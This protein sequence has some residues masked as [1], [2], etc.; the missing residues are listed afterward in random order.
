MVSAGRR[1]REAP[2]I[3]TAVFGVVEVVSILAALADSRS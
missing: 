3:V 2:L 1:T